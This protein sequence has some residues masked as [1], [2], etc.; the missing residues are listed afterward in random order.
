MGGNGTPRLTPL[1]ANTI[2]LL[3]ARR[4]EHPLMRVMCRSAVRDAKLWL[5]YFG[6][7]E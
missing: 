7:D 1:A 2:S 3:F 6:T 4:H 5:H